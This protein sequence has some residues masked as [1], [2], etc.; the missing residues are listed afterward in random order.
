[1][2]QAFKL[3]ILIILSVVSFMLGKFDAFGSDETVVNWIRY[4][5][6]YMILI[7]TL[8]WG[9]SLFKAY[10][11]AFRF[12]GW[13]WV[14]NRKNWLPIVLVLIVWTM[15]QLCED[16]NFKIL[17][18]EPVLVNT[19]RAMHYDR[20]A[21]VVSNAHRIDNIL[22]AKGY[23]DKRPNFF[24]FL[25]SI[26]HDLT[27][28]RVSNAFYLNAFLALVLLGLTYSVT[29]Q[30]AGRSAGILALGL[31]ASVP[32]VWHQSAGAGFEIL[33]L[34]MILL[35]LKVAIDFFQN[36]SNDKKL[37]AL[38]L[39][40]VMLS[41]VRY[42]SILFIIPVAMIVLMSWSLNKKI[43]LPWGVWLAPV[44]L[45]PV[46]WQQ[47][48]FN[49]D[50]SFWELFTVGLKEPFSL[51]YYNY[52][53]SQALY[54]F[55]EWVRQMPNAPVVAWI[56]WISVLIFIVCMCLR[57]VKADNRR[58]M[59]DNE[60]PMIV[61]W[62]FMAGFALYF[63]VLMCYAFDLSRYMVQRLALPL[64]LII[65]ILAGVVWCYW[66]SNRIWHKILAGI[67]I[68]GFIGWTIPSSA[69]REYAAIYFPMVEGQVV[70][71]F[72]EEHK[73][74]R[75][76]MVADMSMLWTTYEVEALPN[77]A[78]NNQ[79]ELIKYFLEHPNN[80]TIYVMQT[81]EYNPAENRYKDLATEPLLDKAV[82]KPVIDYRI[83]TFRI[84]RIS[85]LM[86]L[87]VNSIDDSDRYKG[88]ENHQ[89]KDWIEALP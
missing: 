21:L 11:S 85:R 63:V 69:A 88:D 37:S 53:L 42:E 19:S 43:S 83:G 81:L 82:L 5:G 22:A 89:L 59:I 9:Y 87:R 48:V 40:A 64:Y 58:E 56:G 39:T 17:L 74:E 47:R 2:S 20:Q 52:N 46:L 86:D 72:V 4:G 6:Y 8:I 30:I 79:P 25:I 68:A 77:R 3:S 76:L 29:A 67:V 36:P 41:Q 51:E 57:L 62:T 55:F 18:D 84:L 34:V 12:E 13:R 70:E 75:Y 38:C 15:F 14:K 7:T 27:G 35:T 71:R 23:V 50:P 80:P 44:A 33:N 65:V 10:P 31:L 61:L 54:F 45:I 24:P 66:L 28:Y 16:K 1:M 60:R 78:V 26:I 32:L 73:N 49:L